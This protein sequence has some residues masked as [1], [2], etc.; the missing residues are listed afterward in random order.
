MYW[1]VLC[2]LCIILTACSDLKRPHQ[3]E[4][5]VELEAQLETAQEKLSEISDSLLFSVYVFAEDVKIKMEV[6]APDTLELEK[7]LRLDRYFKAGQ[8]SLFVLD[9]RHKLLNM[10]PVYAEDLRKLKQDIEMGSGERH[11]YEEFLSFEEKKIE[12]FMKRV[13]TCEQQSAMLI[14]VNDELRSVLEAELNEQM[15]VTLVQLDNG[16]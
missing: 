7:A 3:L 2:L 8:S 15:S 16:E 6:Y 13:E 5:L 10:L 9:E 12:E 1:R 4:R 14:D 11:R